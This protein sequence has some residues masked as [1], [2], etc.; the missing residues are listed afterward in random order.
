MAAVRGRGRGRGRGRPAADLPVVGAEA[1]VIANSPNKPDES[2]SVSTR[3]RKRGH[4]SARSHDAVSTVGREPVLLESP[5]SDSVSSSLSAFEEQSTEPGVGGRVVE[6]TEDN[7]VI[8]ID[9]TAA[10]AVTPAASVGQKPPK[11]G[12]GRLSKNEAGS[13]QKP[14]G[15]RSKGRSTNSTSSTEEPVTIGI[16]VIRT[17]SDQPDVHY[18]AVEQPPKPKGILKQP[19]ERKEDWVEEPVEMLDW[20]K[21]IQ[22]AQRRKA[23]ILSNGQNTENRLGGEVV[24]E[25]GVVKSVVVSGDD[26]VVDDDDDEWEDVDDDEEFDED[27]HDIS[28]ESFDHF[29]KEHTLK[30]DVVLATPDVSEWITDEPSGSIT[31]GSQDSFL[32]TPVGQTRVVDWGAEMD[33][34]SQTEQ[35]TI[36]VQLG[37]CHRFR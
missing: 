29:I 15:K 11:I 22:E 14:K 2:A 30:L 33:Q 20:D 19:R 1:N 28:A 37:E 17:P 32:K 26:A 3:P 6:A 5:K 12:S 36:A 23:E 35:R 13:T 24:K 16:A 34:L 9:N 21:E 18:K 7:I 31:A 4:G 27:V 8:S 25:S 10:T